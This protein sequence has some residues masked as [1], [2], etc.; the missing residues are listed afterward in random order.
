MFRP[1]IGL[2]LLTGLLLGLPALG[3]QR[4]EGAHPA[5]P[6]GALLRLGSEEARPGSGIYSVRFS[7]DGKSL[8]SGGMDKV[9]R[10]WDPAGGK[11]VRQFGASR[12][13]L[14]ALGFSSDGT[15]L[16]TGGLDDVLTLWEVDSG[17]Q[18]LEIANAVGTG[19]SGGS[20]KSLAFSPDG[21]LLALA[22]SSKRGV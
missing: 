1:Y 12:L 4:P 7:P 5:L 13:P 6:A 17:K 2:V 11:L 10:L 9:A 22:G 8:A 14:Q 19:D 18:L 20:V 3:Q 15:K 16:A 21:T